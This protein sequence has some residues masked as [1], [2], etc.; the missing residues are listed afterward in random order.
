MHNNGLSST[1]PGL[2]TPAFQQ[3][4]PVV[5]QEQLAKQT[6][7]MRLRSPEIAR[8]I[9][10]GQ[11]FMI[12]LPGE[13]ELTIDNGEGTKP[14]VLNKRGK[15]KVKWTGQD[16]EREMTIVECPERTCTVN[17]PGRDSCRG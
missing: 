17:C 7:R 3:T 6:Y 1:T 8:Q 2:I 4:V 14:M 15:G 5:E 12:R 10:P 13:T 9:L 11:F 16:G